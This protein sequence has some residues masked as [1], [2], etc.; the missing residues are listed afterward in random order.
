MT[1]SLPGIVPQEG[2]LF[3]H[4]NVAD[5]IAW[6]LDGYRQEKYLRVAAL[7][8]RV[9]S[10][11]AARCACPGYRPADDDEPV[12]RSAKRHREMRKA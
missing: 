11:E 5:N 12:A 9:I 10:P 4:L 8:V 6:G 3:P 1:S 2:A 7:M